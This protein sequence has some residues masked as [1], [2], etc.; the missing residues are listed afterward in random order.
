MSS[1]ASIDSNGAE[2]LFQQIKNERYEL[3]R[4]ERRSLVIAS[5]IILSIGFILS[6][7]TFYGSR[8]VTFSIVTFVVEIGTMLFIV[9]LITQFDSLRREIKRIL[10]S[11]KRPDYPFNPSERSGSTQDREI[12][13]FSKVYDVNKNT[14]DKLF[15]KL[16]TFSNTWLAVS[17][18]VASTL[19]IEIF[20]S[21][22]LDYYSALTLITCSA[23]LWS[24]AQN[25]YG[26]LNYELAKKTKDLAY[27]WI[28]TVSS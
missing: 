9:I 17:G 15:D 4:E 27:W 6:C 19:L 22:T 7:L 16:K 5:C 24:V 20:T 2:K 21:E 14:I 11:L 13:I 26:I 10:P 23:F 3:E 28:A 1:E 18:G 25:L 8:M 12:Q